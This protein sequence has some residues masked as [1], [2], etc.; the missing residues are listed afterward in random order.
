MKSSDANHLLNKVQE[1]YN[2]IAENFA[3]TREKMWPEI[4]FLKDYINKGD[5][6][7]DIGCGGGRLFELFRDRK[8]EYF[9]IDFAKKLIDI[10][11]R[12]Y[13]PNLPEER[14]S[15][16][17]KV[18]PTFMVVDA[19]DLPFES[20][21]FDKVFSIAV[22]HHIPSK[23][24]RIEFLK[25][26]KR[27]LNKKGELYFTVWNLWQKKYFSKILKTTLLKIFGKTELDYCDIF[28]PFKG[29]E[30]YYH[31]FRTDELKNLFK[32]AEFKIKEIKKL[33]RHGKTV[34]IYVRAVK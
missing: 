7:L 13:L 14:N 23:E 20:D 5:R 2:E 17:E 26:V 22:F 30:R 33:K 34:N 10:A 15:N 12:K 21:F 18:L 6:V 24:K 1:D 32:E 9:G 19:L 8:I 28:V 31:C 4:S 29:K 25:E 16:M 27:V 3:R 11:K